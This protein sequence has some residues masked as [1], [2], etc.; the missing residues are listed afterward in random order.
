M[1]ASHHPFES[2]NS[3]IPVA[4][5]A[6]QHYVATMRDIGRLQQIALD[7]KMSSCYLAMGPLSTYV[8]QD[9]VRLCMIERW[10]MEAIARQAAQGGQR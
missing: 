4:R 2:D 6:V 1:L 8:I 10:L 5:Q 3:A 7:Q 9:Q